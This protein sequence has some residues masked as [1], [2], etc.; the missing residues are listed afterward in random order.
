M[1]AQRRLHPLTTAN[2][3]TAVSLHYPENDRGGR[4]DGSDASASFLATLDRMHLTAMAGAEALSEPR[5]RDAMVLGLRQIR[6][7]LAPRL[8]SDKSAHLAD[9]L[10]ARPDLES[11]RRRLRDEQTR[12]LER[13]DAVAELLACGD[14]L[15]EIVPRVV[16]LVAAIRTHELDGRDLQRATTAADAIERD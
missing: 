6:R 3:P 13:L 12:L 9:V 7:V 5:R 2:A 1:R 10:E 14:P 16:D 8:G 4:E 15:P 11:R